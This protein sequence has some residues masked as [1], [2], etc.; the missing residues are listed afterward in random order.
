MVQKLTRTPSSA[1]FLRVSFGHSMPLA[2][3]QCWVNTCRNVQNEHLGRRG[4]NQTEPNVTSADVL[5]CNMPVRHIGC[6]IASFECFERGCPNDPATCCHCQPLILELQSG[7]VH[8][9]QLGSSLAPNMDQSAETRLDC[10]RQNPILP[11]RALKL[12]RIFCWMQ[13]N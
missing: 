5:T 8:R 7:Q 2:P 13:V 9:E 10:A 11:I 12:E 1:H 6:Q 4:W 3:K